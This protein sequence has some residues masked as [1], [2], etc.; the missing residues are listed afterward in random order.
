MLYDAK[1]WGLKE[2]KLK[3]WQ[4]VLLDAADYIDLHGWTQGEL[5][6][7]KG[8]VCAIGSILSVRANFFNKWRAAGHLSQKVGSIT[9][10]NDLQCSNSCQVIN[11]MRITARQ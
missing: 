2:P 11:R 3:G 7:D 5:W 1:R 9:R 4:R 6:N 10:W 8:N